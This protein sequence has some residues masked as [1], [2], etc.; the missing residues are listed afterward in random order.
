MTKSEQMKR[1]VYGLGRSRDKKGDWVGVHLNP[2][3][4]C[5]HTNV[6]G[7]GFE[8][9]MVLIVEVYEEEESAGLCDERKE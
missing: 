2:Y 5:I 8:T 3:V 7:G 9:M 4:N 1:K 6:G